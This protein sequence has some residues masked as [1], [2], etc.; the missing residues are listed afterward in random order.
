MDIQYKKKFVKN[1]DKLSSKLQSKTIANI[2]IFQKNPFDRVLDNHAL[3]WE[4]AGC[5][6]INITGDYRAIFKDLSSWKYEFVE[7]INVWTHSQLYS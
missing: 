5:R 1:F 7:F 4:Y 3:T 6:S 2:K